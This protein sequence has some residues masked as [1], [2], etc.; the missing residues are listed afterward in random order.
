M[1]ELLGVL[2]ER[3]NFNHWKAEGQTHPLRPELLES[4]YF[5]HLATIGLHG[6]D[7]GPCSNTNTTHHTSSWL[8]PADFALHAVHKLSWTPCGFATINNVGP[9][10]TGGMDLVG[11]DRDPLSEQKHYNIKHH[12]E[13]PSYFLSETIKYLYLIFDAENNILH[14]DKER[15]W[16]FT[17]E[18][19]PIHYAPIPDLTP[20]NDN[21]LQKQ[22]EKIR[23]MLN[24]RLSTESE[25][26]TK[27]APHDAD[28]NTITPPSLHGEK[29]APKTQA[30]IL[31]ADLHHRN[32]LVATSKNEAAGI[33]EYESGPPFISVPIA[34]ARSREILSSNIDVINQAHYHLDRDGKGSGSHLGKQCP[35]YHH[36]DLSWTIA[37]GNSF[38]EYNTAHVSSVSDDIH[39]NDDVDER[40]LTALASVCFY[41]TDLY[42]EGIRPTS[43]SCPNEVEAD[44]KA[45]AK[46]ATADNNIAH[47]SSN[48]P[49]PGSTRYDMGVPLGAFDVSSFPGGDGFVVRHVRTGELLEVSIF[50]STT[51]GLV[52][53]VILVVLT[54]PPHHDNPTDTSKNKY[55]QAISSLTR[56]KGNSAKTEGHHEDYQRHV[57]GEYFHPFY[58][59]FFFLKL[60]VLYY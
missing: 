44:S 37:L 14:N 4:C 3:F 25:T 13:M 24:A 6:S 18:A 28:T 15:E 22:I 52:G 33:H 54:I 48:A 10:T 34:E 26:E 50:H 45:N 41:G 58:F 36:P 39:Q 23:T 38:L 20:D 27:E 29:W 32:I 21:T 11:A 7:R 19:H 46:L 30:D 16:I 31:H 55:S 12:N 43:N 35:N 40:M 59:F 56:R 9:T 53:S 57:V 51:R 8:W 49:I 47:P 1:R 60:N 42:A 17:T 5:L 2:P